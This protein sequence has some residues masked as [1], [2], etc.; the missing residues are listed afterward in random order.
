MDI[1]AALSLVLNPH[2]R[3][4]VGQPTDVAITDKMEFVPLREELKPVVHLAWTFESPVG[5]PAS[6][7]DLAPSN[8]RPKFILNHENSIISVVDG[9]A[10]DSLEIAL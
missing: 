6:D 8:G 10:Q 3:Q 7:A 4:K 5:M 1:S 9:N 2:N